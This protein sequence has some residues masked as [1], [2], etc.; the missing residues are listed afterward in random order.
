M[1]NDYRGQGVNKL[2]EENRANC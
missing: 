2:P 1:T